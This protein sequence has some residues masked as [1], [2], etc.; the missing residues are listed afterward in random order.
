MRRIA[1]RI[2]MGSGMNLFSD[3]RMQCCAFELVCEVIATNFD[4]TIC[5][6]VRRNPC[7]FCLD[8]RTRIICSKPNFLAKRDRQF[9]VAML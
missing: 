8:Q 9:A 3:G 2:G 7:L 4:G 5:K 6:E 1:A